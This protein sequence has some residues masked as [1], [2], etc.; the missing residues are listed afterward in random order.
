MK[1]KVKAICELNLPL[2]QLLNVLITRPTVLIISEDVTPPF[3]KMYSF[4][5]IVVMCKRVIGRGG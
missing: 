4:M 1:G 3:W 2:G 5:Q